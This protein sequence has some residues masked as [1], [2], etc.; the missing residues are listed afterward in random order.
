MQFTL[1]FRTTIFPYLRM[2]PVQK[3]TRQSKMF[4]LTA[5]ALVQVLPKDRWHPLTLP[6]QATVRIINL[7]L[8]MIQDIRSQQQKRPLITVLEIIP[9]LIFVP[10]CS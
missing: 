6:S 9:F 7:F 10:F 1:G 3:H 2:V 5:E 4:L 8:R